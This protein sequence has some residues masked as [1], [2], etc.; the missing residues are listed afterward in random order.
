MTDGSPDDDRP[1]ESAPRRDDRTD[2]GPRPEPA[3]GPGPDDPETPAEWLRWLATT[4]HGGV[5]F[6]RETLLSVGAV[7][8]VGLLLFA[9][10]GIWPPMVAVE[11]TSM[12]PH[13]GVGDLVFVMEEGRFPPAA[14]H[15]DTGVVTAEDGAAAGYRKFG[16]PGDVVVYRPDGRAGATPIIHRAMFWVN[17]SENW[18]RRADPD[19]VGGYGGCEELPNCPAP[20]AG[21][22]TKGDNEATNGAYDQVN[23]LSAPVRPSWVVGTAELRIPLLGYVKLCAS[24]GPC[25]MTVVAAHGAPP[26]A[27]AAPAPE[28]TD[29][30]TAREATAPRGQTPHAPPAPGLVA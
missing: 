27:T 10:S 11:S 9:V 5:T 2:P 22:V 12:Q 6:V 8:L 4:D 15:G 23:G 29:D 14:A 24:G 25:P 16:A 21:F 20:H 19:D 30:R 26:P 18:Y 1:R 3:A 17:D 7:I 13:M 28:P